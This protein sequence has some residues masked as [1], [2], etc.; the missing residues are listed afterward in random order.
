MSELSPP[1]AGRGV[2]HPTVDAGVVG[3]QRN[4]DVMIGDVIVR[5]RLMVRVTHWLVALAFF[6]C[7]F[8]GF[9]IWSPVFGWMAALVGGLNVC[10]WLHP[11]SGVA[12][13]V[14]TFWMA[15][16]WAGE[17]RMSKEERGWIG[18]R[19]LEYMRYKGDDSQV[20]KYNP[21]QKMFFW[22]V[23]LGAI[24]VLATGIVMWFPLSFNEIFREASYVIHDVAFILFFVAIVFHIYLGTI[25]EPGTFRSM[26]RGTVTR[27]W[28]RLH[29]PR[30]FR[31]VTG[32]QPR[33]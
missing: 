23:I 16:H 8:T 29:H 24:G 5:H 26:T 3:A 22:T 14:F 30:W 15:L 25:G 33:R 17:M 11:W 7:L 1:Y 32:E 6:L 4:Q 12:F 2:V 31:E 13:F 28:A 18:P 21:G 9:P 20:G 10:R 19:L 27:A